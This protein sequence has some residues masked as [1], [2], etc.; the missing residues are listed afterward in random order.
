MWTK[1]GRA[2]QA[3]DYSIITIQNMVGPD[4][5]QITVLLQYKIW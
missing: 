4:R 5:A 2:G 1:Y 3:T